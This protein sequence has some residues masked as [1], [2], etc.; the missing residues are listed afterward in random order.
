MSTKQWIDQ[1]IKKPAKS[2]SQGPRGKQARL[3]E[4]LL[5]IRKEKG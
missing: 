2:E 4:M 3:A 1:V 5:K